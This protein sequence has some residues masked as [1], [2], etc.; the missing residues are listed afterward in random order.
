M[1]TGF[2]YILR[3][4]N[5]N[6]DQKHF[7]NVP[8][9]WNGRLFFGPCK[10]AIRQKMQ[11]GDYIFGISSSKTN[12]RRIIFATKI[13]E[14]ITFAAA[15]HRFPELRAEP[16][17]EKGQKGPIHVKPVSRPGRP[18]PL[19]NYEHINGAM[20]D[21]R[22][23]KDLALEELDKFF[24]GEQQKQ[25]EWFGG[26]FG[27]QGPAIDQNILHFLKTCSVYNG[28]GYHLSSRNTDATLNNPIA[29]RQLNI[30]LHLE[31]SIPERLIELCNERMAGIPLD[32]GIGD[33]EADITK[34][35]RNKR[36]SCK[37]SC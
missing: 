24:I 14:L 12:P 20:H 19:C 10:V 13:A 22:W 17:G 32:N 3:S 23:E 21:D 16:Q 31:T 8:T 30:G 5:R 7:C 27:R 4:V 18:F 35:G 33:V 28:L 37:S 15:Y 2:I 11:S 29:Y 1:A 6:Y 25:N 26:W 34:H 9:F 36:P